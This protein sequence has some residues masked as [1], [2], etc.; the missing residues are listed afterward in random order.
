MK[1]NVAFFSEISQGTL[2]I[3]WINLCTLLEVYCWLTE[4]SLLVMT[5][6]IIFVAVFVDGKQGSETFACKIFA[7]LLKYFRLHG[8]LHSYCCIYV[9]MKWYFMEL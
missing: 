2:Y 7:V 5:G 3:S 1:E 9:I 6:V 4:V 8:K